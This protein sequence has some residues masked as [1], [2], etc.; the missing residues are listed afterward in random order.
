[1]VFSLRS[2]LGLGMAEAV[3]VFE[4]LG[5]ACVPGPLVATV[6]LAGTD[7]ATPVTIVEADRQP[8]LVPHLEIAGSLLVLDL[9]QATL[10]RAAEV[11]G[12]RVTAPVDPLTPLTEVTALPPGE[13]IDDAAA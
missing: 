8:L 5:R 11:S 6:L 12:Q 2:E 1:G 7:A 13:P 4:E 9:D 10:C 3:L